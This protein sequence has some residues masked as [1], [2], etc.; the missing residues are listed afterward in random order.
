MADHSESQPNQPKAPE[1]L[2]WGIAYLREDIQ[3]VRQEIQGVRQEMRQEI[4]GVRQEIQGVRQEFQVVYGRID[5][6]FAM[7][8]STMIATAGVLLAAIKH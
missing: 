3:D 8:M 7:L 4:Q 1:E 6:R 5:S 2:H